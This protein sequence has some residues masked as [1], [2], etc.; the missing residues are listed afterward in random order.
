MIVAVKALD[1]MVDQPG[2]E[3][4]QTKVQEQQRHEQRHHL[5]DAVVARGRDEYA[6]NGQGQSKDG[7]P[8][9]QGSQRRPFLSE[10]HLDLAKDEI[11]QLWWFVRL[12]YS[13]TFQSNL[14]F[15]RNTLAKFPGIRIRS[16]EERTRRIE[17][18]G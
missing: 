6:Q 10:E 2:A 3:H 12:Q 8:S 1:G 18:K 13:F 16:T 5:P 17:R 11:V 9:A 14:F 4:D 15:V 7:D